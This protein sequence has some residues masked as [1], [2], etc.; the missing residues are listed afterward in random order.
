MRRHI[1]ETWCHAVGGC[2]HDGAVQYTWGYSV[3]PTEPP[4]GAPELV[5][6]DERVGRT[7][8][9]QAGDVP[10]VGCFR[11]PGTLLG[12]GQTTRTA[13]SRYP[14]LPGKGHFCSGKM[15]VM[16]KYWQ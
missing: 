7:D 10:G 8:V 16:S 9:H 4:G 15:A 3:E 1:L 6:L 13:T 12:P 2:P 14:S 11:T 5:R